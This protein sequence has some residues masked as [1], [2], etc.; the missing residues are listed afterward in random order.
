MPRHPL[1]SLT[2]GLLLAATGTAAAQT[3]CAAVVQRQLDRLGIAPADI[4]EITP[5][6]HYVGNT[7]RVTGYEIWIDLK[8]CAG[9]LLVDLGNGCDLREV[10]TRNE[11]EIEG[12]PS[13]DWF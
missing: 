12:V 5:T 3:P 1:C 4:A 8:S 9:G 7:N 2:V 11:C 10:Y 13:Y 6:P